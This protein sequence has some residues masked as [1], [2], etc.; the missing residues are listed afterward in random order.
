MVEAP[1]DDKDNLW[2]KIQ[3]DYAGKTTNNNSNVQVLGDYNTGKRSLI[4]NLEAFSGE[5]TIIESRNDQSVLAFMKDKKVCSALDYRYYSVKNPD[6]ENM[7]LAK[8]NFWIFDEDAD[9]GQLDII[10]NKEAMQNLMVLI[11][12]DFEQYWTIMDNLHKYYA[13]ISQNI[14]PYMKLLN[15]SEQ[16]ALK[17][18]YKNFVKNYIEPK[19][20]ENNKVLMKRSEVDPENWDSYC[21]PDGLLNQNYGFSTYI[22][23]N[24][25]EQTFEMRKLNDVLEMIEYKV[26]QFALDTAASIFY[27]STKMDTNIDAQFSYINYYFFD[28]PPTSI[29][30]NTS[31]DA[32][33]IPSGYDNPMQLE[34]TFANVK[35]KLFEDIIKKPNDSRNN[36]EKKEK[37]Q[38]IVKHQ[39][40][41]E[42]L[43][44][45][46]G[47]FET[48]KAGDN[49]QHNRARHGDRMSNIEKLRKD[50]GNRESRTSNQTPVPANQTQ[51]ILQMLKEKKQRNNDEDRK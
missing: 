3:G 1:K 9:K 29:K 33:F 25:C 35:N 32:L 30:V 37:N 23:L 31:K 41:L 39:K 5:R 22:I 38:N 17:L 6:D 28:I 51:K 46:L 21:L 43:K 18:R 24:K 15:L 26:R 27:T 50:T 45:H 42:D 7:E 36:K 13:V 10:L 8:I 40:F 4:S 20:M 49:E 19:V 34:Q 44:G 47:N 12:L 14:V 16:D 48:K 11:V 2:N